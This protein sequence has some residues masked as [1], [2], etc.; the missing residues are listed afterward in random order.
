MSRGYHVEAIG[1]ETRGRP[2]EVVQRTSVQSDSLERV[3][4]RAIHLL[5]RSQ[6]PQWAGAPVEAVRVLD[7]TGTEVFR[8]SVWDE[9]SKITR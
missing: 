8:W 6:V 5:Q 7:G 1:P 3:R 9:L 4:Q 2:V